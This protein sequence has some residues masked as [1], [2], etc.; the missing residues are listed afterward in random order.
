MPQRGW[1]RHAKP[2]K[3]AFASVEQG[4][5]K[6]TEVSLPGAVD[7]ELQVSSARARQSAQS[8][9]SKWPGV[10]EWPAVQIANTS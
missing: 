9:Q 3:V 10:A 6:Q 5:R 7:C 1:G 4:V 8:R 2:E